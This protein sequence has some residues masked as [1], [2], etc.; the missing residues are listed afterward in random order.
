MIKTLKHFEA[1]LFLEITRKYKSLGLIFL[2]MLLSGNTRYFFIFFLITKLLPSDIHKNVL[3]RMLWLPFSRY[4]TFL[5]SYFFGLSL[6]FFAA[7]IGNTFLFG[8]SSVYHLVEIVIFYS[9][10]YGILMLTTTK[11]VDN[12]TFPVIFLIVD[13]IAG[14]IG[15]TDT[16]KYQLFSPLYHKD[17]AYS[18]AVALIILII[19]FTVFILDRK[20]KW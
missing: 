15:N 16:N 8:N 5:F 4:E 13:L 2:A 19:S 10:Y 12:V 20:E 7:I 3:K 17:I 9:A 14:S 11:G 1:Y 18:L 6:S